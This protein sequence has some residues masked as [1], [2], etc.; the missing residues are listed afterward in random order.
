VPQKLSK[1]E[2]ADFSVLQHKCSALD[3]SELRVLDTG[4]DIPTKTA[5]ITFTAV[6]I[7]CH[8]QDDCFIESLS[9]GKLINFY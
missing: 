9:A 7:L 6:I 1:T 8:A 4:N 3:S 2:A 5:V